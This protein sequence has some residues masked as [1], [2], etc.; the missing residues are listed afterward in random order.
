MTLCW[1]S[2]C[3]ASF[4]WLCLAVSLSLPLC[5]SL[6]LFVAALMLAA[7]IQNR[8]LFANSLLYLSARCL[9]L[10]LT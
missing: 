1:A 2:Q 3:A 7:T 4:H 6:I 8:Y 10:K 9:A 5:A